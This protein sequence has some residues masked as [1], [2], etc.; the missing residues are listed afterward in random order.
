M[1]QRQFTAK[2]D[3]FPHGKSIEYPCSPLMGTHDAFL[4]SISASKEFTFLRKKSLNT[5]NKHKL[6]LLNQTM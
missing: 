1:P 5:N 2:T 6:L 4:P 3:F